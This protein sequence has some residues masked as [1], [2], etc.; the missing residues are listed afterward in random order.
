MGRSSL[1]GRQDSWAVPT[2]LQRSSPAYVNIKPP[3]A[4]DPHHHTAL[5]PLLLLGPGG[6]DISVC[7]SPS[8]GPLEGFDLGDPKP[9]GETWA[10]LCLLANSGL[11]VFL[12]HHLTTLI[13]LYPI[14]LSSALPGEIVTFCLWDLSSKWALL[15]KITP[16]IVLWYHKLET[17]NV[18]ATNGHP[19]NCIEIIH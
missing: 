19:P 3:A 14:H 16:H 10:G 2:F 13:Y 5:C 7:K 11:H 15:D 12:R 17:S 18:T 4:C 6:P 8:P 9:A 1:P